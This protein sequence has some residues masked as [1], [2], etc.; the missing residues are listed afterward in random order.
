MRIVLLGAPGAGKGTQAQAIVRRLG[1]PH[2]GSGALLR[3]ALERGDEIG[4][5]AKPYMD[6]GEL[7]PDDVVVGM[8]RERIK[9]PDCERGFI[10]EGFPRTIAQARTLDRALEGEGEAIDKVA[11][12]KVSLSELVRRLGGRWICRNC[13]KPYHVLFSPP[14]VEGRC[15]VCGG[16]LYQRPDD[17]DYTVRRRIEIY[18]DYMPRVTEYYSVDGKL[19]EVDG[20]QGIKE[21][22]RELFWAL[23]VEDEGNSD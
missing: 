23:G 17:T 5:L 19:M 9:A 6:R 10:L 20:E 4:F 16:E 11:Y 7:V 14:R 3:G 15:D 2:I 21:V 13:Q 1:V 12:I 18:L 22:Q 8:I